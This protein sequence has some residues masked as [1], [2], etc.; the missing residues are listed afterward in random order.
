MMHAAVRGLIENA[1]DDAFQSVH[2]QYESTYTTMDFEQTDRRG[3]VDMNELHTTLSFT[4][5]CIN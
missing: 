5:D 1:E 3:L 2:A 4:L